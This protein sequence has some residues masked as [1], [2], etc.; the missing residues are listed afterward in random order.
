MIKSGFRREPYTKGRV[1]TRP[2]IRSKLSLFRKLKHSFHNGQ[3]GFFCTSS[4]YLP[5]LT[6]GGNITEGIRTQHVL[7]SDGSWW[8]LDSATASSVNLRFLHCN[9][10]LHWKGSNKKQKTYPN[11]VNLRSFTCQGVNYK[12]ERWCIEEGGRC[13][14]RSQGEQQLNCSYLSTPRDKIGRG[15]WNLKRGST[16]YSE[17]S[18]G[19]LAMDRIIIRWP[20][21]ETDSDLP[22]SLPPISSGC[23]LLW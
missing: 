1:K 20:H 17:R 21:G 23:S 16:R 2:R 12:V 3:L 14:P 6:Q 7:E 19:L 22:S 8:S 15:Y 13:H 5:P 11:Q 10:G 4:F 9:I 18:S